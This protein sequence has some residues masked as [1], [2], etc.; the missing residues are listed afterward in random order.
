MLE[1][2]LIHVSKMGPRDFNSNSDSNSGVG[3]VE[4]N[5]HL[6]L[7]NWPNPE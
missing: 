4:S 1:L 2:K 6:Q 5:T 3:V 7:R